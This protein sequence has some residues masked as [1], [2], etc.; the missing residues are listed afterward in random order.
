MAKMYWG[1]NASPRPPGGTVQAQL[2]RFAVGR[3]PRVAQGDSVILFSST[4]EDLKFWGLGEVLGVHSSTNAERRTP[5]DLDVLEY[6]TEVKVTEALD[7]PRSLGD[8]AYSLR[9]VRRHDKPGV[10]YNKR[11]VS[12]LGVDAE[13]IKR[14]EIHGGRAAIGILASALGRDECLT[15]AP[16]LLAGGNVD[17]AEVFRR[18]KEYVWSHYVSFASLVVRTSEQIST[19]EGQPTATRRP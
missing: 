8:L 4:R 15:I 6:V 14:N 19:I 3:S 12:M 5:D 11:Y 2:G 1:I 18:L 17:Y 10:H 7:P 13:T 9:R 16:M